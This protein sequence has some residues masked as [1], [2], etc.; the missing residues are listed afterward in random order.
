MDLWFV[1]APVNIA[2]ASLNQEQIGSLK[3]RF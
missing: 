1:Q 2:I 3:D